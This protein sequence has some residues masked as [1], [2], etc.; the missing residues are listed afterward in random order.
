MILGFNI[1]ESFKKLKEIIVMCYDH[2]GDPYYQGSAATI[3]YFLFLS[4][5]PIVILASQALGLFSLSIDTILKWAEINVSGEGFK[6]LQSLL[7][8]RSTGTNNLILAAIA[9]WAAS[10]ANIYLVR[11]ANYTFYD[12]AVVGKGYIR[13]RI[14]SLVTI[15]IAIGAITISLVLLVY[16]PLYLE[17]VI[18][19]SEF[20][21]ALGEVWLA[22]R[23]L[24]VMGMY[25]LVVS[26]V[27]Y[28][29]P[30]WR[31]NYTEIIPGSIFTSIGMIVVSIG[32]NAYVSFSTNYDFLYGSFANAVAIIIWF[33]AIGWV[34]LLGII[35]NR[36][37]W[38]VR[39]KNKLPIPEEVLSK[40][41]PTGFF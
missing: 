9:V 8:H 38:A 41:N 39:N 18:K 1:K 4:I 30:S 37:W 27:F 25:F 6:L 15:L 35:F 2:L 28:F 17:K 24:V 34:L 31:L 29:L 12:G 7:N 23:W 16:A 20:T 22:M 10:R 21:N 11:L 26:L 36:V 3:A 19:A 40:R 13:D 32:F 33:W 14:R 5:L